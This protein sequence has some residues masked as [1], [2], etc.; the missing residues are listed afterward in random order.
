MGFDVRKIPWGFA[1]VPPR[2]TQFEDSGMAHRKPYSDPP[3]ISTFVPAI[4]V[5][6]P[7][8]VDANAGVKLS[9]VSC[10]IVA[11]FVEVQNTLNVQQK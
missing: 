6:T 9:K 7:A 1:P 8:V 2:S 5:K 4:V 3:T 10:S 11:P